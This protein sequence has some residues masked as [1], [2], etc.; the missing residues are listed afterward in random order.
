MLFRISVTLA[1]VVLYISIN[2]FAALLG[3]IFANV[4]PSSAL[5]IALFDVLLVAVSLIFR[6][7]CK[8][9]ICLSLAGVTSFR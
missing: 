1:G 4:C 6:R 5:V 8:A 9:A 2:K 7:S 3:V